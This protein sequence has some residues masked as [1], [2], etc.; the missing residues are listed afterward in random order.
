MFRPIE[1]IIRFCPIE[2]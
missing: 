2:L 1:A